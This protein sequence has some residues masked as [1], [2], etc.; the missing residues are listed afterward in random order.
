MMSLTKQAIMCAIPTLG[1]AL[2]PA[3]N[4]GTL[5]GPV[6][7][8]VLTVAGAGAAMF[9]KKQGHPALRG[10]RYANVFLAILM[11]IFLLVFIGF[12]LNPT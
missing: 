4:F 7:L 2:V 9:L 1:L 12:T 11:F 8:A 6:Y 10:L 3:V 5:S